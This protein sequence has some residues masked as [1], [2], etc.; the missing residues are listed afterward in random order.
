MRRQARDDAVVRTIEPLDDTD[1]A[2]IARWHY[3]PPYD[4]YDLES[5]PQDLAEMTDS[6]RRGDRYWSARD[7]TGALV[8]F[9]YYAVRAD[10]VEVGV[11]LRPDLTGRGTGSAFVESALAFA[12]ER[13]APCTF[14][15]Y[16]AE[17]N[18]RAV[19]VYERAGF[20]T[21]GVHMRSFPSGEYRFVEMEREA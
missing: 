16:V 9:Y 12:R 2:E 21:V 11:G 15:L 3:D 6:K 1:A 7:E 18:S 17:F 19:A 5:D 8:G 14:R 13:F 4:F 10:E 20:R